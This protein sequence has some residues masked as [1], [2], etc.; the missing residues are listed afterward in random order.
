[1]LVLTR[2]VG[3]SILIGDDIVVTVLELNRDQVR[4]GIRA[5]RSVSVHREEVYREILLSNQAAA[6]DDADLV[7]TVV[8]PTPSFSQLPRRR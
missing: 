2:R 6:A 5:P 8:G 7:A 4:I 3:E 1:M